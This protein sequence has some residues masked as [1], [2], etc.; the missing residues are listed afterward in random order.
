[1]DF[2]T[3]CF[4]HKH[5]AISTRNVKYIEK[6]G[7]SGILKWNVCRN[8]KWMKMTASIFQKIKINNIF[9]RVFKDLLSFH[10]IIDNKK[11]IKQP[12]TYTS[13]KKCFLR[14]SAHMLLF[15]S[16]NLRRPQPGATHAA[17][18]QRRKDEGLHQRQLRGCKEPVSA[19]FFSFAH[20]GP[21]NLFYSQSH[22]TSPSVFLNQSQSAPRHNS[23][24]IL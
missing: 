1:M 6:S 18:W 16:L 7:K 21:H 24:P 12:E 5:R 17:G 2:R 22:F 20:R 15:L 13:S 14:R 10:G 3:I 19:C 8:W 11:S 9:V 23:K 4:H